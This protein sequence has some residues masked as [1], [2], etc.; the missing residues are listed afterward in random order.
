MDTN[1]HLLLERS[2]EAFITWQQIW[3]LCGAMQVRAPFLYKG[4]NSAI[5]EHTALRLSFLYRPLVQ[6]RMPR[7][8]AHDFSST[9]FGSLPTDHALIVCLPRVPRSALRPFSGTTLVILVLSSTGSLCSVCEPMG[10]EKLVVLQFL[11]VSY[12]KSGKRVTLLS[13]LVY[14]VHTYIMYCTT[15]YTCK[16][17]Y[18]VYIENWQTVIHI[19][20]W[21]WQTTDLS[22]CQRS[23]PTSRNPLLSQS[24]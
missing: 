10:T 12:V 13:G 22:S 11:S 18:Y 23:Y 16:T 21:L 4:N 8:H 7:T 1:S 24:N 14:I 5:S 19:L 2:E 3:V 6:H 17:K 20:L 9:F 15:Y